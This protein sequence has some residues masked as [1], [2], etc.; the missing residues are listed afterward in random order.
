MPPKPPCAAGLQIPYNPLRHPSSASQIRSLLG[1]SHP[2]YNYDRPRKHIRLILSKPQQRPRNPHHPPRD[3][4]NIYPDYHYHPWRNPPRWGWSSFKFGF[5]GFQSKPRQEDDSWED[6][7]QRRMERIKMEIEADPYAAIFGRRLEPFGFGFGFRLEN[8]ITALIRSLFGLDRPEKDIGVAPVRAKGKREKRA[9][10]QSTSGGEV[11]KSETEGWQSRPPSDFNMA[12]FEYDPITGRMVAIPKRAEPLD[13]AEGRVEKSHATDGQAA[14]HQYKPKE[15]EP[16]S[17]E[18]TEAEHNDL[19]KSE[20]V[21]SSNQGGSVISGTSTGP[22]GTDESIIASQDQ[23]S[24]FPPPQE[25]Q[26]VEDSQ[27]SSRAETSEI[28]HSVPPD[29][30]GHGASS[31]G[32]TIQPDQSPD[33]KNMVVPDTSV[34]E[35]DGPKE[36]LDR[37]G[38]LS[39]RDIEYVTSTAPG[40][41]Q[42][43]SPNDKDRHL[44]ELRASD[45]RAAY[46][47]RRLSI[48]SELEAETPNDRCEASPPDTLSVDVDHHGQSV[49]D[50]HE[51]LSTPTREWPISTASSHPNEQA[52]DE[53]ISHHEVP[54]TMTEAPTA[55]V[56]RILA[57]DPSS[58]TVTEAETTSSL[59]TPSKHVHPTELLTRLSKPAKFL[60]HL[61]QMHANGYEIVSGGEDILVF[62]KAPAT[63]SPKASHSRHD[64]PQSSIKEHSEETATLQQAH[65]GVYTGNLSDHHPSTG[66]SHRKSAP[67]SRLRKV[68]QRMLVS[69]IATGGTCYALGVVGE[70]FRTGGTDGWG[71]DGFTEF[72]SE[73]RHM[74]R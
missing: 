31:G 36:G 25:S 50:H 46:D 16:P 61:S 32:G 37:T 28:E 71:I 49:T 1:C 19:S 22:E 73:R 69:G 3:H 55:E 65:D 2:R 40:I 52:L 39:R 38:F 41:A 26:P 20:I 11:R 68:L 35:H 12:G 14:E 47:S 17:R 67:R 18:R 66:E 29:N 45:I 5:P 48:E 51:G 33:V 15:F 74:E 4:Q 21:D 72:E 7:A 62:R 60:P 6:R 27:E 10:C 58:S 8:R 56:Y 53:N 43:Q 63:E 42:A 23:N 54:V 30:D 64:D 44:D 57:Y 9:D 59:Q 70:Y 34:I 24:V 13:M